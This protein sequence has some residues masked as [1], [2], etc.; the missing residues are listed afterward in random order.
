MSLKGTEHGNAGQR[1]A[2]GEGSKVTPQMSQTASTPDYPQ[3]PTTT[4]RPQKDRCKWRENTKFG[5]EISGFV[6]LAAYTFFSCMQWLQI[7]DT[8][9]LTR[10]ALDDNSKSL[11]QTLD[12]MQ[13]QIN[14]T[15]GLYAEAQ[16][17]TTQA[18]R[19]ATA[20]QQQ[21]AVL[22]KQ[23]T[24]SQQVIESQRA[25]ISVDFLQVLNPVT[26]HDGGLSEAFSILLKNNGQISAT[27]VLVRFKPSFILW[28]NDEFTKPKKRQAELCDKPPTSDEKA[29][30]ASAPITIF[31]GG[32]KEVQINFGVGK[33]S[34]IEII[35]WP[36][37]ATKQTSRVHPIVV[38]CIDYQS[39]A[40]PGNH[41]TGFIFDIERTSQDPVGLSFIT[42]GTDVPRQNV[43]ITKYYFSQGKEY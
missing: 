42:F 28:G 31:P 40:I 18:M 34:E 30:A 12:K 10:E 15:N 13:A 3:L 23:Y 7:R 24:A 39:G 26:F 21:D 4:P 9:R 5:L 2:K 25:S 20:S 14:V 11:T 19:L 36:P 41:Q 32:V 8:N 1:K 6:V 16:K 38:G 33:P 27:N 37:D 43:V 22:T 17:Q 35:K 29:L